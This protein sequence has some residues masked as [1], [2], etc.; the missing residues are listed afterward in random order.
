MG[1]MGIG[2]FPCGIVSSTIRRFLPFLSINFWFAK[3]YGE[4]RYL[5]CILSRTEASRKLKQTAKIFV[6]ETIPQGSD[7]FYYRGGAD[8]VVGAVGAG[9][10]GRS[11]FELPLAYALGNLLYCL[12]DLL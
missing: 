3:I 7:L 6:R 2:H 12:L 11:G 10:I 1:K 5:C 8:L 4:R 9:H